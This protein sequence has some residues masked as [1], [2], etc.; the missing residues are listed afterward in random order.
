MP[1]TRKISLLEIKAR[2]ELTVKQKENRN[3]II[4]KHVGRQKKK[5]KEKEKR[6]M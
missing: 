6:K 4:L 3:P 2:T 5:E 1:I